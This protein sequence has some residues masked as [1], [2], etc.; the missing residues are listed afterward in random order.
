MRL[1]IVCLEECSTL[2]QQ[3]AT[4]MHLRT[5]VILSMKCQMSFGVA[6]ANSVLL[7]VVIIFR[8]SYI[9]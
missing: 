5:I 7:S 2:S 9:H 1:A 4:E 6:Q 8:T 3:R